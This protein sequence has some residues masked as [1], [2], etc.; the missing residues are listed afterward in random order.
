MIL[1][2]F[3]LVNSCLHFSSL[4]LIHNFF[5]NCLY[6][7]ILTVLFSLTPPPFGPGGEADQARAQ[8]A[9]MPLASLKSPAGC[10]T[11]ATSPLIVKLQLAP[12]GFSS[13]SSWMQRP[14]VESTSLPALAGSYSG[15]SRFESKTAGHFW[16]FVA[17]V[18]VSWAALPKTTQF[19]LSGPY[20]FIT[21]TH[22]LF[23]TFTTFFFFLPLSIAP[24][25]IHSNLFHNSS[26]YPVKN[27]YYGKY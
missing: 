26:F 14:D 8:T 2:L 13:Y 3:F 17:D 27:K 6:F 10:W 22:N 9:M 24:A 7:N 20:Q 15:P 19:L 12:W 18:Y 11:N 4:F 1:P 5:L 25:Q 21:R 16:L 23:L